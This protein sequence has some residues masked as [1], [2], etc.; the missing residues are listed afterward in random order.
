VKPLLV[1]QPFVVVQQTPEPQ[2]PLLSQKAPSAQFGMHAGGAHFEAVQTSDSQSPAAPHGLVSAQYGEQTG[3]SH[4]PI[5]TTTSPTQTA[6]WQ[7]SIEPQS[8]SAPQA[9]E[10]AQFGAH[11]GGLHF[12][13]LPVH[14][15]DSQ[16]AA[17]MHAELSVQLG[18]HAGCPVHV[19][20]TLDTFMFSV[21]VPFVTVQYSGG[22]LGCAVTVM[23]YIS[24]LGTIGSAKLIAPKATAVMLVPSA[25]TRPLPL[26]PL[27]VPV[28]E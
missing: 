5:V 20:W 25:M 24:P 22:P 16:S 17:R 9:F 2:S 1:V 7:H 6:I 18:E 3:A 11:A 4:S 13:G 28:I 19:T 14:T 23:S 15:P 27:I 8:P 12:G 26:Y 21:P 10:S